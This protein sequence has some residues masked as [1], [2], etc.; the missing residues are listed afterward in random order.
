MKLKQWHVDA[1]ADGAFRGNPA[2]VVPLD[3]WLPDA[4]MQ[5]CGAAHLTADTLARAL[6]LAQ[7][8]GG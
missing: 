6:R 4:T 8:P 5:A 3:S 7:R 1:F 2:A